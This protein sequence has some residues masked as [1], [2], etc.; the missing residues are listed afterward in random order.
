MAPAHRGRDCLGG[1][2]GVHRQ[3]VDAEGLPGGCDRDRRP[4]PH[5]L[6]RVIATLDLKTTSTALAKRVSAEVHQNTTLLTITAGDA[7]AD[8]A[9]AIANEVAK[10]LIALSPTVAA[11]RILDDSVL[12]RNLAATQAQIDQAQAQLDALIAITQ[13]SPEQETT[14]QSLEN[15]LASLRSTYAA[16][17]AYA[18]NSGSNLLSVVSPATPPQGPAAPQILF[19]TALGALAGLVAMI[20]LAFTREYLDDTLKVPEDVEA[21]TSLPTL[22]TINRIPSGRHADQM[23]RLVTL[24]YPRSRASESFRTLRTNLEFASIDVPI[25]SLLVTSSVPGEGKTTVAANLAVA[26]AQAGRRTVLVDADLRHPEVHLLFK[27][28]NEIGL[29]TILRSDAGSTIN[30]L[31]PTDEANLRVL[32]SGPI[33]P[34]PAELLGSKKMRTI[35]ESLKQEADIV[36]FDSPP[37]RAVTDAAVLAPAVDATLLIIDAGR[38][39]RAVVRQGREALVRVGARMIG[40]TLNRVPVGDGE[41][42]YGS[43]KPDL[44]R[45]P[46]DQ[47]AMAASGTRPEAQSRQV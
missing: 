20:A 10:E 30:A 6:D 33:P 19:N 16:L 13:R 14:V 32:T 47:V 2:D 41:A 44:A 29:T 37:L 28:E 15:R 24:L 22:G 35:I 11:R 3:L 21:E 12:E 31:R 26:F 7:E 17:L 34:N 45:D 5:R 40:A 18:S 23:Y 46:G 4:I 38:T 42:Y 8:R 36:V 27:C 9:A 1:S 39:R 43:A 25:T